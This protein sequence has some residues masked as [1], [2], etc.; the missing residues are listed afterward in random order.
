MQK[1]FI[2]ITVNVYIFRQYIFLGISRRALDA[3]KFDV[4]ENYYHNRTNKNTRIC[5][6]GLDGRNF[7]C[8]EISTFT[9]VYSFTMAAVCKSPTPTTIFPHVTGESLCVRALGV[10]RGY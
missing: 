6:L 7:S 3:R 9:V 4:S 8:T 1:S 2:V 5:P 10:Y